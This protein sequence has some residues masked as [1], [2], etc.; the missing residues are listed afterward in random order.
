[1]HRG[2]EVPNPSAIYLK[3]KLH[4]CLRN[5]TLNYVGE[6][7]HLQFIQTYSYIVALLQAQFPWVLLDFIYV[8][9][10]LQYLTRL[11]L[12]NQVLR[13][14]HKKLLTAVTPQMYVLT[15]ER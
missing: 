13:G 10:S 5:R 3:F 6:C 11:L 12:L 7:L 4:K 14:N 15:S 1:V 9:V 2:H 8:A